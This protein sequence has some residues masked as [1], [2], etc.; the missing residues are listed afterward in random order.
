MNGLPST[1]WVAYDIN[2]KNE[3]GHKI[4]HRGRIERAIKAQIASDIEIM[5]A[6]LELSPTLVVQAVHKEMVTLHSD[7]QQKLLNELIWH[8]QA[9]GVETA[10]E[11]RYRLSVQFQGGWRYQIDNGELSKPYN[12]ILE[13]KKACISAVI[14][15]P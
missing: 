9:T 15:M 6:G 13:A 14:P 2:A 7:K 12:T 8:K 10:H 3:L 11:R 1:A 5:F 4:D